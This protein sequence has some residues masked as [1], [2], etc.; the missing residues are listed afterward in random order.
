MIANRI[1][2]NSY[3]VSQVFKH[4]VLQKFAVANASSG[5]RRHWILC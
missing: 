4:A 2:T 3:T 5:L 1:G